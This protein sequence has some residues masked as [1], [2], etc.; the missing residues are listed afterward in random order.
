MP[1]FRW[2]QQRDNARDDFPTPEL[3]ALNRDINAQVEYPL[4][5]LR[6]KVEAGTRLTL[7]D[8]D[9]R[10]IIAADRVSLNHRIATLRNDLR[11]P[12]SHCNYL[13]AFLTRMTTA[14]QKLA[15]AASNAGVRI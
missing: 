4:Q 2:A 6:L 3:N 5:T 15:T 1:P 13:D 7:R 10:G 11:T 12:Q 14:E 9:N 8:M